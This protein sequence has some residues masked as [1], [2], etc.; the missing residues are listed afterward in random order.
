MLRARARSTTNVLLQSDKH[1]FVV[2][3]VIFPKG[4]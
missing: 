4:L 2:H 3:M 1:K